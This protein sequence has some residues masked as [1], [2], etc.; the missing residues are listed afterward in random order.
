MFK[1]LQSNDQIVFKFTTSNT[2][3][4]QKSKTFRKKR[5]DRDL[6]QIGITKGGRWLVG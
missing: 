3:S 4:S 1:Q 5:E 2:F 6:N